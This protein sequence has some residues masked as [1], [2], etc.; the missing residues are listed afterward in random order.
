M[1]ATV[2]HIRAAS[3]DAELRILNNDDI[4]GDTDGIHITGA[5]HQRRA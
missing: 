3:S 2:S 5:V 1:A 4:F